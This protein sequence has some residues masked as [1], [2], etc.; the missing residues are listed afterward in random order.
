[1][2][3]HK[4]SCSTG[5]IAYTFNSVWMSLMKSTAPIQSITET[6]YSDSRNLA[7]TRLGELTTVKL[8]GLA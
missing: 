5:A 6:M 7:S 8:A 3:L 1:M 2:S 4:A